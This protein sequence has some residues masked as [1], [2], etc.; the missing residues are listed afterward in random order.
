MQSGATIGVDIPRQIAETRQLVLDSVRFPTDQNEQ[1]CHSALIDPYG[2]DVE[3]P[4][5]GFL[6]C[7]QNGTDFCTHYGRIISN[8]LK[9][10][11]ELPPELDSLL[12]SLCWAELES[13]IVEPALPNGH[14]L[15]RNENKN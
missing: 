9:R 4:P 15:R 2:A 6:N 11:S 3:Q 14:Y 13:V 12:L 8:N 1:P 7:P 10:F 5:K